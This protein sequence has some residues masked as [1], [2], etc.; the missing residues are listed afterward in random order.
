[1]TV[2]FVYMISHFSFLLFL[3][4]LVRIIS[5]DIFKK[6]F[7]TDTV[8]LKIKTKGPEDMVSATTTRIKNKL[9]FASLISMIELD[10]DNTTLMTVTI[11]YF[12]NRPSTLK[13]ISSL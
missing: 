6:D 2:P 11:I 4:D 13:L 7:D 12:L 8:A 10:N 5:S 1:M 9:Q 3:P